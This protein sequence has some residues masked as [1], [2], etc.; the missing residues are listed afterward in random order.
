MKYYKLIK[1][2]IHYPSFTPNKIYPESFAP[3]NNLCDVGIHYRSNLNNGSWIEVPAG[4]YFV[5]EG[6]MPE[7]FA[8]K[9]VEDNPLWEKYICWLNKK[10]LTNWSGN[11]GYCFYGFGKDK[12]THGACASIKN[13]G[14][15]AVKLTLEQWDKIVNKEVMEEN[16]EIIGWKLKEDFKQYEKAAVDICKAQGST[17]IN[18][19]KDDDGCAFKKKSNASGWL[20]KAG[21]LGLWFEPVYE[22]KTLKFGGYDVTFEKVTSGVRISCNGETGTCGQIEAIYNHF[23]S[24]KKNFSFGSQVVREVIYPNGKW[25]LEIQI[26]APTSIK[27]G[28]TTGTWSEFVAIYEK[29]KSML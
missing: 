6:V 1:D 5:Q 14:E 29:A 24:S 12:I 9:R 18:D 8:I 26:M 28:C 22:E 15:N 20:R 17:E 25:D 3:K 21:V 2:A 27:I 11:R 19:F 7:Y 16:K 23:N 4:E 13:F 10:Y